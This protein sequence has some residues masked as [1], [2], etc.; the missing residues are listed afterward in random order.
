MMGVCGREISWSV[1]GSDCGSDGKFV[2]VLYGFLLLLGK[3]SCL[4]ICEG[5]KEYYF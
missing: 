5:K 2:I 4:K 3:K 1:C